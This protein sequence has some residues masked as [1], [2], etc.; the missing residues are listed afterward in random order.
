MSSVSEHKKMLRQEMMAKRKALSKAEWADKSSIIKKQ[1]LTCDEYI[2]ANVVHCFVS[3]NARFE[4]DTH[5][6]IN[7]MLK[8][9]KRVIIP[10][11]NLENGNLQ[12]SELYDLSDLRENKWGVL[13][14]KT[15]YSVEVSELE[16]ILVPLLAA[17]IHGNRLGYGKGFYDRFLD[18]V[19][20]PAIALLF[21]DFILDYIPT[22]KFDKKVNGLIS[23]KG[24][25]RT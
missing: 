12:H 8:Q 20:A 19:E 6:L 16:L 10:V 22:E 2:N 7:E 13:E 15:I 18:T 14:P 21:Q 23:E 17:D 9:N 1:V 3:M 11:T 4:V 5:S 25:F 24:I